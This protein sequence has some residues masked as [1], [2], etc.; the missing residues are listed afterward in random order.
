MGSM[1][2][3]HTGVDTPACQKFKTFLGMTTTLLGTAQPPVVQF[4][5]RSSYPRYWVECFSPHTAC[6]SIHLRDSESTIRSINSD[7]F[8]DFQFS[9]DF[10]ATT[11]WFRD[12]RH[13]CG[14]HFTAGCTFLGMTTAL[15]DN[16]RPPVVRVECRLNL[17]Q[18][19]GLFCIL[20]TRRVSLFTWENVINQQSTF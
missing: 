13:K 19:F 3:I 14:W 5:C 6:L 9:Q 17:P 8:S 11:T 1:L 2:K 20:H 10:I 12:P 16:A 4:E 18:A 7:S 15:S